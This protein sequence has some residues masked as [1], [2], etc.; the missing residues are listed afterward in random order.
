MIH[1]V[2]LHLELP[3]QNNCTLFLLQQARCAYFSPCE[4]IS[5]I[6][7]RW[8]RDALANDLN[9]NKGLGQHK[10]SHL[11]SFQTLWSKVSRETWISLDSLV[12]SISFGTRFSSL[13]SWSWNTSK[14]KHTI[15]T[16]SR[17]R[18]ST[19]NFKLN[20]ETL[21]QIQVVLEVLFFQQVPKSYLIFT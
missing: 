21:H 12:P 14:S 4:S 1:E 5:S 2:Q 7:S 10:L 11:C 16:L 20:L 8:T 9:M 15:F 6:S 18:A 13:S 17:E 3:V 19:I